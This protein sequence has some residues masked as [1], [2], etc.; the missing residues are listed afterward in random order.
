MRT[1]SEDPCDYCEVTQH[2][3]CMAMTACGACAAGDLCGGV[4]VWIHLPGAAV[5]LPQ[6][7]CNHCLQCQGEQLGD[8]LPWNGA[9]APRRVQHL[10]GRPLLCCLPGEQVLPSPCLK[11]SRRVQQLPERPLFCALSGEQVRP[12]RR[13]M[14]SLV[15]STV[16][17]CPREKAFTIH[18]LALGACFCEARQ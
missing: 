16:S 15:W 3:E 5:R 2:N 4:R 14:S 10:P 6:H 18:T 11:S 12:C 7:L 13:H 9:R 17:L 1:C 8:L